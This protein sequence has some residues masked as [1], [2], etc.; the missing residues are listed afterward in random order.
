[1]WLCSDW[2]MLEKGFML[3]NLAMIFS[4]SARAEYSSWIAYV[5]MDWRLGFESLLAATA[6]H[7]VEPAWAGVAV[8]MTAAIKRMEAKCEMVFMAVS[9]DNAN[10]LVLAGKGLDPAHAL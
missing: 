3:P 10:P 4:Y 7:K 2:M 8:E 6:P 5:S 1:M 9:R